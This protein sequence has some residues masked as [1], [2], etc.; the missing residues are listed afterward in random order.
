LILP[1]ISVILFPAKKE[2]LKCHYSPSDN[3]DPLS[4]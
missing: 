3:R 1:R 2:I 4:F